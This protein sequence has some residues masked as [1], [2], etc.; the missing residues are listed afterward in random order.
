[1]GEQLE[2]NFHKSQKAGATRLGC[3]YGRGELLY[4]FALLGQS[5]TSNHSA[6]LRYKT[7]TVDE[8][9]VLQ[10]KCHR[11]CSVEVEEAA[12]QHGQ[13]NASYQEQIYAAN[14]CK[15]HLDTECLLEAAT[16]GGN[17]SGTPSEIGEWDDSWIASG[18]GDFTYQHDFAYDYLSHLS[19]G[20]G[21]WWTYYPSESFKVADAATYS[22]EEARCHDD[23][24]RAEPP[25]Y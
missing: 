22:V 4:A 6:P 14:M 20:S 23:A 9:K 5:E 17:S 25:Q 1:M 8:M 13:D 19:Y 7:V 15:S 18:Y 24:M 10:D 12:K 16:S 3:V 2:N 21:A 11:A